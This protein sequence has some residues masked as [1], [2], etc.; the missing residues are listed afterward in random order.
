MDYKATPLEVI[1]LK[2][3]QDG[4]SFSAYA[5]TYGNRDHGGDVIA[6]GAFD[7]S[8]KSGRFRPLL[9][10][11]DMRE[12]I[13][14]E[15]SLKS[16]SHGLLGSWELVDT[17]RGEDAYKLLKRGALRSMSIGYIPEAFKF[18]DAGETRVLEEVMLLENS[19]VSVPMNDGARVQSVKSKFCPECGRPADGPSHTKSTLDL[20]TQVPFE[21]LCTQIKGHLI[22]GMGEAE[23]LQA[24]RLEDQRSLTQPHIDALTVLLS[25]L[26]DSSGRIE[27]ILSAVS[28]PEVKANGALSL[29]NVLANAKRRARERD[30]ARLDLGDTT[31]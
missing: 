26:K 18:D 14:I 24:R 15:K 20:N 1:E 17:Q 13:G 8:L 30:R 16:D 19:L 4:W 31:P 7:N 5:S 28:P 11:H 27:A 3:G 22:Y 9:W 12:P 29:H 2:A 21:E 25:E 23:A 10:Q 6:P